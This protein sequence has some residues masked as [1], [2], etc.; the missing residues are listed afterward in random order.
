MNRRAA[1]IFVGFFVLAAGFPALVAYRAGLDSLRLAF[2]DLAFSVFTLTF[3]PVAASCFVLAFRFEAFRRLPVSQR[4]AW[5]WAYA[6]LLVFVAVAAV[7]DAYSRSVPHYFYRGTRAEL[8][9]EAGREIALREQIYTAPAESRD[10]TREALEKEIDGLQRSRL[11]EGAGR[12]EA[13]FAAVSAVAWYAL[14]INFVGFAFAAS[15]L[16]YLSFLALGKDPSLRSSPS[17]TNALI[18]GFGSLLFWLPLRLFS[19]WHNNFYSFEELRRFQ[20]LLPIAAAILV[21]I[22]MLVLITKPGDFARFVKI[23]STLVPALV[24]ALLWWQQDHLF[25][26][27]SF[28]ANAGLFH[29]LFTLLILFAGIGTLAIGVRALK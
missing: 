10:A 2:M 7:G 11:F 21:S 23:T 3:L 22:L 4:R 15:V 26:I 19:E 12:Q 16:W 20:V 13:Y 8:A 1:W 6:G 29:W 9:A 5:W 28:L 27:S 18:I 24:T 25:M 17:R 14:V